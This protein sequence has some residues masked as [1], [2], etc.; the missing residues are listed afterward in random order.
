M[1]K[2]WKR[3]FVFYSI[4]L[5]ITLLLGMVISITFFTANVSAQ[6]AV[7]AGSKKP[8][9]TVPAETPIPS[10]DGPAA[11]TSVDGPAAETKVATPAAGTKVAATTIEKEKFSLFGK[12][13]ATGGAAHLLQGLQWAVIAVGVI[14]LVGSLAGLK[15]DTIKALSF[16]VAGG[17]L[18]GKALASFGPS[19]FNKLPVGSFFA[20]PGTQFAVGAAVAAAIFIATY[21][22][23]KKKLVSFQCLPFEPMIGGAKC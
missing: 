19:G 14:Q 10:V 21:K 18:A 8:I 22:K 17:I 1:Q 12:T 15:S 23:E 5:Q 9:T 7:S 3:A 16:A 13:I 2:R 6:S 20:K 4:F 11:G